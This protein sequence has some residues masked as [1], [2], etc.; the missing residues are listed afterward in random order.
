MRTITLIPGDGIGPEVAF[1][2]QKLIDASGVK[3]NW[4]IQNAGSQMIDQFG[5]PLPKSVTDSII[6]NG[7]ALKGPITTP[8]GEGFRSVNV[9]LRKDLDLYVNL[10]PIKT[11]QG[12]PSRYDDID[13]VIV[14][15]NTED[16]YVGIEHMVGEDAAESIKVFTRKG[17]ERICRYAFEYARRERRRKVTA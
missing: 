11:Y 17:C 5:T 12:I 2:T 7:I 9:A 8:V 6:K 10:R 3:L 14:R 16:L 4:E 13:I 15:E 1:A